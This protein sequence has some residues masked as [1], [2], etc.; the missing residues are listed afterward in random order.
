ME[1][2]LNHISY[3]PSFKRFK[4]YYVV[5]KPECGRFFHTGQFKFKSYYVVW[6]QEEEHSNSLQIYSLN[7]T[8]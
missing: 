4:S 3:A 8:M 7:R 1:T 5:W 6:K 2:C